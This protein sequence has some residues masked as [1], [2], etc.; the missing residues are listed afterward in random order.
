MSNYN[1]RTCCGFIYA[2]FARVSLKFSYVGAR[3]ES[4]QAKAAHCQLSST[5]F[6]H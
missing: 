2:G 6:R 4:S 1:R 5:F 3:T